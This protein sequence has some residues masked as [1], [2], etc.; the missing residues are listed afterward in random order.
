MV[1]TYACAECQDVGQVIWRDEKN[2]TWARR[3]HHPDPSG[4]R[5]GFPIGVWAYSGDLPQAF[6]AFVEDHPHSRMLLVTGQAKKLQADALQVCE[7]LKHLRPRFVDAMDA[8][9]DFND[10][11][12]LDGWLMRY[13]SVGLFVIDSIDRRLRP[14]QIRAVVDLLHA[15]PRAPVILIGD[16]PDRHPDSEPWRALSIEMNRRE[17]RVA[18]Y[19]RGV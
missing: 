10:Q 7:R 18:R 4:R 1:E 2:L 3:C 9:S 19:G 11:K 16:A 13:S 12:G 14:P 5:F 8:P 6:H 17:C 15:N